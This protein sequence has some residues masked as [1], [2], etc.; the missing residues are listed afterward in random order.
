MQLREEWNKILK[1]SRCLYIYGAGKIG[2]KIYTLIKKDNQLHKLKAFVVSDFK[3]A[4]PDYIDDKQV[5]GVEDL[6]DKNAT[7]LVS[8]S[9]KI[10][11]AHV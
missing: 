1:E 2:K 9:D 4:N 10:G 6:K 5:I 11:R 8:V 3:V 7:V